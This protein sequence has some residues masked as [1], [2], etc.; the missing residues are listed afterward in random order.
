MASGTL[1]EVERSD[2][3]VVLATGKLSGTGVVVMVGRV[4]VVVVESLEEDIGSVHV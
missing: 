3:E 4:V 2:S 1:L